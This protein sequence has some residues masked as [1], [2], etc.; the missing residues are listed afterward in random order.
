MTY[1]L[2]DSVI[3]AM[4]TSL[5]YNSSTETSYSTVESTSSSATTTEMGSVEED[6]HFN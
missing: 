5:A 2:P 1:K 4:G 6:C 3:K